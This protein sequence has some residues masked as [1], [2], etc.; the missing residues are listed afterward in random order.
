MVLTL[1][2][3]EEGACAGNIEESV[4]LGNLTGW[5]DVFREHDSGK[6]TGLRLASQDLSEGNTGIVFEACL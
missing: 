1:S 3:V 4:T 5:R 2:K 6:L